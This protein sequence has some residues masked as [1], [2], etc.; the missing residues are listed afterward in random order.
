MQLIGMEL[1]RI[2]CIFSH[3]H[4]PTVSLQ[5]CVHSNTLFLWLLCQTPSLRTTNENITDTN[6][7]EVHFGFNLDGVTTWQNISRDATFGPIL[8]YPD[9][10]IDPFG[11]M[12]N[13]K[14]YEKDDVLV[15]QVRGTPN[16]PQYTEQI[17]F[18][19]QQ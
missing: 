8:Y 12:E 1:S 18:V 5:E 4:S 19:S 17:V 15:I 6:P 14:K 3:S 2:Y 11:G 16:Q 13:T 10:I 7:K 9:P